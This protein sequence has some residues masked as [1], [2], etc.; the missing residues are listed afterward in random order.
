MYFAISIIVSLT[1]S[2][3]GMILGETLLLFLGLRAPVTCW[4]VLPKEA[5]NV[6][7]VGINLWLILPVFA[8][9]VTVLAYSFHGDGVRAA[10]APNAN[11]L[12]PANATAQLRF[13]RA[14]SATTLPEESDIV[15][16]Q[17][18][19]V[20]ARWQFVGAIARLV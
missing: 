19:G 9:I 2:V 12:Q 17:Q 11:P 10:A 14:T 1:L 13:G 16:R 15:L 3:P 8:V 4:G 6:Q 7:T 5:R 18:S 20:D